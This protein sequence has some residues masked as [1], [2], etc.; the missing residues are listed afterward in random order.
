[1][2]NGKVG[3]GDIFSQENILLPYLHKNLDLVSSRLH[4]E[5]Q[6]LE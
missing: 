4:R 2:Q 3:M 6:S 1:M 5:L